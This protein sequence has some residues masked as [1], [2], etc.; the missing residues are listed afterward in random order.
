MR[1]ITRV[2]WAGLVLGSVATLTGCPRPAPPVEA[3]ALSNSSLN[4][5][6]NPLPASLYVWNSNTSLASLTISV[7][8]NRPW[9]Q[10]T[11]PTVTSAAPNVNG[12]TDPQLVTV[13][14]NRSILSAGTHTG[15]ITFTALGVVT[16]TVQVQV[17]QDEGGNSEPLNIVN[18]VFTYAEPFLVDMHFSLKDATGRSVVAEPGQFTLEAQEG[19]TQVSELNGLQI[20]RAAARQLKAN[21]VLD[22]SLSMQSVAGAITAMEDAAKNILLPALNEDAQVGIWEF[23]RDDFPPFQVSG[24]TVDRASLRQGIDSIQDDLVNGFASGSRIWDALVAAAQSF[25]AQNPQKESRY[26]IL[27]SNGNDTS[28]ITTANDAVAA[29]QSR[30]IRIYAV[31][32]G[33]D[34]NFTALQDITTRTGGLYFPT[35]DV[36]QVDDV[37]REIVHDL[38]GQYNVRWA[39]LK[40]DSNPFFPSFTLELG[41]AGVSYTATSSFV[42]SDY[43]GDVLEGVLRLVPSDN[44]VETTVFLRAVYVPRFI[45]ELHLRVTSSFELTVQAVEAADDGLVADWD[46]QTTEELG[47]GALLIDLTSPGDTPLQFATFGPL[48]RFTFDAVSSNP[49]ELFDTFEV[50]NEV[51]ENGQS[52]V[53]EGFTK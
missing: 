33:E 19:A 31:A 17:I 35:Q 30:G 14:I 48:L 42:P 38:D 28:S 15:A 43:A 41:D 44:D 26:L 9:I 7:S 52:F 51:Y 5:E 18:P 2:C 10:V 40:R 53:V 23:H 45:R 36:G 29:A 46:I 20:K 16:K 1:S 50:D 32:F 27:F 4:F 8:S 47:T 39:S 22:Y 34:V 13:T 25:S 11:P 3:I 6:R 49:T 37:F 24:F 21:L 12:D